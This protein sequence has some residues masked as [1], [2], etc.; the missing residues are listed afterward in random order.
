MVEKNLYQVSSERIF[1][2][3]TNVLLYDWKSI[4]SFTGATIIVPLVVLEEL[5]SFKGESSERGRNAR[6]VIRI[7]D[8]IR[9]GGSLADGVIIKTNNGHSLLRVVQFSSN[10]IVFD[11]SNDNKIIGVVD[12]LSSSGA[13]VTFITKDINARVKTDL[14]GL[15]AEDYVVE[16]VSIETQ[17]KGWSSFEMSPADVKRISIDGVHELVDISDLY[18]NQFIHVKSDF[19]RSYERLFKFVRG[20]I[21]EVEPFEQ[22]WGFGEKNI[23]QR[24]ALDLLLDDSVSL[25]SLIGSAGTGKTFLTLLAGMYKVLKQNMYRKMLIARPV[26][27]LGSDIGFLPGDVNEKLFHWMQPMH[28]NLELILMQSK[29]AFQKLISDDD[30]GEHQSDFVRH[31]ERSSRHSSAHGRHRRENH[32]DSH[33]SGRFEPRGLL[34]DYQHAGEWKG[35]YAGDLSAGN[36]EI[37]RLK[38]KGILS[39]EAITYMRGRSIPKQFIFIDEV[40]N[41]TPHEVKTIVSRAGEG[42]KV[43]LAGDPDQIDSPYM[44]YA[45]NGL[46]VTTEK[47]K[48]DRIFGVV[49]LEICERSLLA[50]RA[51]RLL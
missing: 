9:A 27:A 14:L 44:D 43:I 39:F 24:M 21:V 25:L 17:Y 38:R 36:Q 6:R 7:F 18:E 50:E 31:H 1:V 11:A 2:L 4:Y 26:V 47:F 10:D 8:E 49:K 45:T 40:Q 3:D 42:T 37:E 51:A 29:K 48:G 35:M 33:R 22:L 23:Q 5:D 28:D 19:E 32:R 15:Q 46:T 12:K 34:Q 16:N 30:R 41:L 20:K 13:K